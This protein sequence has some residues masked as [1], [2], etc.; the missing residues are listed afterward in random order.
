MP[1]VLYTELYTSDTSTDIFQLVDMTTLV[2][3]TQKIAL[4]AREYIPTDFFPVQR[5]CPCQLSILPQYLRET[6]PESSTHGR[7][8]LR[9]LT[10]WL[11]WSSQHSSLSSKRISRN[12][13]FNK[14]WHDLTIMS[15][16]NDIQ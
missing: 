10:V 14:T 9:L 15:R 1:M 5:L 8:I 2:L 11:D 4:W 7:N 6:Q 13:H 12:I 3:P 16:H